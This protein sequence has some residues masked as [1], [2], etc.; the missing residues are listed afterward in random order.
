MTEPTQLTWKALAAA[1]DVSRE[2]IRV[3]RRMPGAPETP[4]LAAW[5]PQGLPGSAEASLTGFSGTGAS[6]EHP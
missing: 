2:S 5:A 4:D 3:W 1:L 6:K